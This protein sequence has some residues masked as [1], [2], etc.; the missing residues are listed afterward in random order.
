MDI[1]YTDLTYSLVLSFIAVI[2]TPFPTF[3]G[4][5]INTKFMSIKYQIYNTFP[6]FII[7]EFGILT[8]NILLGFT[9]WPAFIK[10]GMLTDDLELTVAKLIIM[11]LLFWLA[12]ILVRNN[13][14]PE[15][16]DRALKNYNSDT[17]TPKIAVPTISDNDMVA[18]YTKQ[19]LIRPMIIST[20]YISFSFIIAIMVF[21]VAW[22]FRIY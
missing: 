10:T 19:V 21:I 2:K 9:L 15:L 12:I 1:S 14:N 8:G 20:L 4:K 22:I 5:V 3:A 13:L 18:D 7:V 6:R 11:S 17:D 16:E